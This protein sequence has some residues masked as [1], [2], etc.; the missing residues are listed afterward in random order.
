MT[1]SS[2]NAPTLNN[3]QTPREEQFNAITHGVGALLSVVGL[4]MLV[5]AAKESGEVWNLVGASVFGA[6]LVMLYTAS[7]IYHA[8][9]VG[10]I[11]ETC[12][13]FDHISIYFLIA[14]TYTVVALAALREHPSGWG[15][16]GG[17]WSM[18]A[19][20]I[21][22][23]SIYGPDRFNFVSTLGYVLMGWMV[24]LVFGELTAALTEGA[25]TLLIA[26]GVCYTLGVPFFLLDQ[27]RKFF[28][29]IWHVFVMAGSA[30]HFVM[31]WRYLF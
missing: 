7:T 1:S 14:G 28:H 19:A 29:S 11:K 13:R 17:Q 20:G 24:V 25:L 2:E 12:R 26:G 16:L 30:C 21:A 3:I 18:A 27:S 9:P 15:L 22:V 5:L 4:V 23:K 6:A 8:L 10:E 31:A